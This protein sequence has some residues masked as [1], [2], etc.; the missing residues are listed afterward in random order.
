MVPV[1]A[2]MLL[3]ITVVPPVEAQSWVPPHAEIT[4]LWL[5]FPPVFLLHTLFN[6]GIALLV[7]RLVAQVPDVRHLLQFVQRLLFYGSA[8]L[9]T[10]E[11]FVTEPDIVGILQLNPVF[12][13]LDMSRDVLV[14]GVNPELSSWLMLSTW[15]LGFLILGFLFFWRAEERYGRE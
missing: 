8:V 5:L 14:Y 2:T 4:W 9:F 12:I 7:S 10:F 1:I 3:L 6:M 11:R 15:A 13:I